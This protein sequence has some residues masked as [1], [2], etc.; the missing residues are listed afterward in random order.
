MRILVCV[1]ALMLTVATEGLALLPPLYHTAA[2]I[3]GMLDSPMLAQTFSSG[4]AIQSITATDT[5]FI[6]TTN[7]HRVSV[8]VTGQPQKMPGPARFTYTFGQ[9]QPL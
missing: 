8:V 4:E 5:G 9:A 6:I 2:E 3:K 7:H 1:T